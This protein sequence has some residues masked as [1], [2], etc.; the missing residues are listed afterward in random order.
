MTFDACKR[1]SAS[2]ERD[3]FNSFKFLLCEWNPLM[4]KVGGQKVME[5]LTLKAVC[6][7]QY[8][9]SIIKIDPKKRKL[10]GGENCFSNYSVSSIINNFV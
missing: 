6:I 2:Q 1:F 10:A 3:I 5:M 7:H 9:I 8:W 4:S